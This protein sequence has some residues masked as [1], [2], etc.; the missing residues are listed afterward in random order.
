MTACSHSGGSTF[1]RRRPPPVTGERN[2]AGGKL[3]PWDISER[4]HVASR[5]HEQRRSG[6]NESHAGYRRSID[7]GTG[8]LANR[9]DS[10][11]AS[12]RVTDQRVANQRVTNQWVANQGIANRRIADDRIANTPIGNVVAATAANDT[13]DAGAV[14]RHARSL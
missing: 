1:A 14:A 12:E 2:H 8:K 9:V 10:R 13:P 6:R 5:I 11:I 4:E 3:E 7:I